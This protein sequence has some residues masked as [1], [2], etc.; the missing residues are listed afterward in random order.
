MVPSPRSWFDR[1]KIR[2]RAPATG[3]SSFKELTHTR[4]PRGKILAVSPR[5]VTATTVRGVSQ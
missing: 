3:R 2:T 4:A 1:E 5:S